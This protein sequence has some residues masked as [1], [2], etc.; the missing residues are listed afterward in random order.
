LPKVDLN[1]YKEFVQEVTSKESNQL[2]EMF[3]ATK[4]L[5]AKNPNVNMSLLL[6]G[7]IGLSSETG[8]FNE[9]IKKCIFQGKPLN[10][11]TV[12]HCKRELG[13]IMWYWISSCRALGLDPNE[14]IEENVNKLKARYPGGE[15]DVHYSENRQEGDL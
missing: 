3:Y 15:F 12:F 6:T 10:D 14:V 13:D 8:E 9:I 4:E 2:S 1:K 11:E 5:E 7:G